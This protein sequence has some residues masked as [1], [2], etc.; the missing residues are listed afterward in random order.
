MN[1]RRHRIAGLI[2]ALALV[3]LPG[4]GATAADLGG[5]CCSGL[6]ERIAELEA[7]SARKG[8]RKVSLTVSGHVNE[9]IMYWEDGDEKGRRVVSNHQE[10][11]RFRF[12]GDAKITPEWSAGYLLEIGA[13]YTS[14]GFSRNQINPTGGTNVSTS[15]FD[16]RHS[17]WWLENRALGR[18][19]VGKT[20]TATDGITEINLANVNA[21]SSDASRWKTTFFLQLNNITPGFGASWNVG[22]GDRNTTVKYVSPTVAGFQ[23]SAAW[24]EDDILDAALR[25]AGEFSGIRLAAGVGYKVHRDNPGKTGSDGPEC[26]D[27]AGA[28]GFNN[29]STVD[30][31]AFGLS[32]S[33]IHLHTGL[34][35]TGSYGYLQD[36][37][38]TLKFK[39]GFSQGGAGAARDVKDR[40]QHWY[41]QGGLEQNWFGIGRSTVYGEYGV[42]DAGAGL[43]TTGQANS[44]FS[45][46]N[47]IGGQG[48]LADARTTVWGVGIN[49]E[50]AAA[51][52]DLYVS[53]RSYELNARSSF[54]GNVKG[55]TALEP[56]YFQALM[57]GA[58]IRF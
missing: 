34:F 5:A 53:Y 26:A 52:M 46:F 21:V 12:V 18:I 57:L 58:I 38:R 51:A 43:T 42:Y 23:A 22:E 13:R 7:T 36:D 37:N 44:F 3:G 50:I 48:F 2:A 25:Y 6:E 35:V 19:W 54:D 45:A 9:A 56:R 15:L 39:Q 8:N 30:C 17:A 28:A 49:Q 24:G 27:R 29:V 14:G 20:S 1:C 47:F 40:D 32:A 31:K 55:A 10:R 33:V 16:I 41:L 11:T 4:M